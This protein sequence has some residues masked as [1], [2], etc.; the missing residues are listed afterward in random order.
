MPKAK[1]EKEMEGQEI[2]EKDSILTEQI[3]E[4]MILRVTLS[5]TM[6]FLIPVG[7]FVICQTAFIFLEILNLKSSDYTLMFVTCSPMSLFFLIYSYAIMM[8][9]KAVDI[10][11]QRNNN[12]NKIYQNFN[13]FLY[14]FFFEMNERKKKREKDNLQVLYN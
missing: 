14:F 12:I 5:K 4:N 13:S 3:C 9:G 6:K 8:N 2:D 11:N 1:K 7:A 10:F